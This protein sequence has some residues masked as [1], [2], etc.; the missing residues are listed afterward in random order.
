[1][2]GVWLA[3]VGLAFSMAG[4]AGVWAGDGVDPSRVAEIAAMLDESPSGFGAPVSD[5]A[6]WSRLAENRFFKSSVQA[7]EGFLDAPAVPLPKEAY[8]EFVEK[9][10]SGIHGGV[11]RK[12]Y[13]RMRAFICAEGVENKGRFVGPFETLVRDMCTDVTWVSPY[14]DRKLDAYEGRSMDIDLHAAMVAWCL[15][16]GYHVLGEKLSPEVRALMVENLE[17]RVW[18]P[19]RRMVRGERKANWWLHG[20]NNWT[21]VCLGGVVGSALAMVEPREDRAFFIAVGEKYIQNFLRGFAPDGYCTEGMGYWNYGFSHFVGLAEA[22]WQAT[23]G[24]VDLFHLPRAPEAATF[25]ARFMIG[26]GVYP[27]FADCT[28]GSRPQK[29]LMW[30]V[31]K[32]YG[33]GLGFWESQ[34]PTGGFGHPYFRLMYSFPTSAEAVA[35]GEKAV[36]VGGLRSW[37]PDGGVLLGR[38]APGSGAA[39][40]VALKGGHN[41]EHHNHND[42][43]G[44]VCVVSGESLV[45]DPGAEVYG[46]F[47]FSSRR[48]ESKVMNS[49]GHSV[50][51]IAG[52][53]QRAG[54]YAAARVV[55]ADFGEK[56][57]RLVLDL[58][59]CYDVAELA[60][61]TRTFDYR[62][63]GRGALTVTD[64]VAYHAAESFETAILTYEDFERESE[65]SFK[66]LGGVAGLRLVV[67]ADGRAFDIS[68]SKVEGRYRAS[69]NPTRVAIA[70]REPCKEARVSVRIEPID[71]PGLEP[72]PG[73]VPNGGFEAGELGWQ[74]GYNNF[75]RV[76]DE[77]AASGRYSL[78]VKDTDA[79]KSSN[80]NSPFF[81]LKPRTRY[82]VRGKYYGVSGKGMGIFIRQYD[83]ARRY[84]GEMC[85]GQEGGDDRTWRAFAFPFETR[86]DA[87]WGKV[88][89]HAMIAAVVEGY[90]DDLEVVEAPE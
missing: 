8:L 67:D 63:G 22:V 34:D 58:G 69:G 6:A 21:A 40:S 71:I 75:G 46:E 90:V 28:I 44:F 60:G 57:D 35:P 47:T 55:E 51:V 83:D 3:T 39:M 53:L 54:R 88:Q 73:G 10:G 85:P 45:I 79:T 68:T 37:F 33:M 16:S 11:A 1:M 78:H 41:A 81:A 7:A 48:Y 5:R 77:Q 24:G 31:S 86:E 9:G 66:I 36:T 38:P 84:L 18:G 32:R 49:Y 50:P 29:E 17:R 27:A 74:M 56:S 20:T 19:V 42:V 72:G 15:A 65:N 62:R 4:A 89:V 25:G 26:E 80:I 43:G 87:A 13:D 61:L 14:H 30:F 82:V 2:R 12:R 70:L 23:D 59:A 64:E 76:S 52:Q